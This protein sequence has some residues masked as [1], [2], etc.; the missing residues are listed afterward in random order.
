MFLLQLRSPPTFT[1]MQTMVL[2]CTV[3]IGLVSWVTP[4]MSLAITSGELT[5]DVTSEGDYS[6][7][8]S[9]LESVS[10]AALSVFVNG[11]EQTRANGGLKCGS[12]TQVNASDKY[13]A[14][15]GIQLECEAGVAPAAVPV[16][17]TWRAYPYPQGTPPSSTPSRLGK[18]AISL[19]LPLG[20]NGTQ[21]QTGPFVMQEAGPRQIAPFPAWTI[22][23][24]FATAALLCYGGDKSHLYSNGADQGG[25]LGKSVSGSCF[26]LGNGPGT[27]IWDA[28][29]ALGPTVKGGM[30]ALV[31][32]PASAFHLNYNTRFQP[33]A[34]PSSNDD[35]AVLYYNPARGDVTFCLSDNCKKTQVASGYTVLSPNEGHAAATCSAPACVLLCP[36]E[37]T[38]CCPA[39][40]ADYQRL[41]FSWSATN[42]DNWVTNTSGCPNPAYQ[43]CGN[44][45][46]AIYFKNASGRLSVTSFVN[47]NGTHHI[48]AATETSKQWALS[49]GYTAQGVLGYIDTPVAPP[50][51]T[52][53]APPAPFVWGFGVS[54]QVGTLP[55][56]F[57]QDTL[58]VH[59]NTGPTA[60]WDEW[61]ASIRK[62]WDTTKKADEDV[63]LTSL[64]IWTDNGAA[65]LGP[66]WR[67]MQ[68]NVVP[69]V[70][71][72]LGPNVTFNNWN[73]SMVS[74]EVLGRVAGG[75]RD[76]GVAPRATQL[77]CWWYPVTQPN[78]P[79]WCVSDW[80]LPE[81]FYPNGT[82]GVRSQMQVPL[83][84]YFP[85][86]CLL[87][88]WNAGGKYRWS[89]GTES[90]NFLVPTAVD[91]EIFWSDVFDY[92]AKLASVG[93]D[94]SD[95]W[96]G[97]WAPPMVKAGWKGTNLAAYETDF[98]HGLVFQTPEFRTVFGAGEMFLEGIHKACESHNMTAQI[99]AG[100]P[101][102][103]LEAL[104]MPTITNARAS[105]DYDWDGDPPANGGPRSN[106]GAHNWAAPDNGWVFWATR[107]APSKDN[108]WT[109]N[110]DLAPYGY[111][112][113]S[114]RNGMDAE[115]HAINAILTTGPVGIGDTCVGSTC[116][117][118]AS[119]V[120]RLARADGVLLRP[121]R[122]LAPVD[123][124]WAS[125]LKNAWMPNAIRQM[126]GLCTRAQ[127]HQGQNAS[128][129]S[130]LWQTHASVAIENNSTAP[131]LATSPTRKIVSHRAVDD[132]EQASVPNAQAANPMF[133]M[134][135]L[136]VSV[137]QP[138]EFTLELSDLYPVAPDMFSPTS[139]K[140]VFHRSATLE[141]GTTCASGT[142]AVSSGCISLSTHTS[143]TPPFNMEL[144]DLSTKS[145]A[146]SAG[147]EN[148]L[149]SV[150][151]WQ[152]WVADA[153]EDL[154]VLGDLSSYV[155]LSGYRFRLPSDADV[156]TG[157]TSM[158]VV[159]S[160]E[161][162]IDLTY[163]RKQQ[164][165][166]I[167]MVEHVTIGPSGRTIV[168]LH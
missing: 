6:L 107:I 113:D 162:T 160:P 115:L 39:S 153:S 95:V 76:T 26:N 150:G 129:G 25:L 54:G 67:P 68:P 155:S 66:A 165:K 47:T 41:Y 53:P 126:P 52:P 132:T 2:L 152:V 55:A 139:S 104:T 79:M 78:H 63:F 109:S 149:H 32:G 105:I 137:D 13:G 23:G 21:A 154:V 112:K 92:G 93:V 144:F 29:K 37:P 106:N 31:S 61:G 123:V 158:I 119:V 89:E 127:E 91:S 7:Q 49:H 156:A 18:I 14:F 19:E 44:D 122:P 24:A 131:E 88:I 110:P 48:A 83:M 51:P 133:L 143:G 33:N 130:R 81:K 40:G 84:L 147:A 50:P 60:A 146:C 142:D 90:S 45:D 117:M 75:V 4:A 82:G 111:R 168:S 1:C 27:L 100:N 101:P 11:A 9:D 58:V 116:F 17:F 74:T 36:G 124:M 114:G 163:L 138:S 28:A 140:V 72:K 96:P 161:E 64:T 98:Y 135:H 38:C 69:P 121:D 65:T 134:Q 125:L 157:I 151:L 80:V 85:A 3:V 166:W 136:V 148:C 99:C 118:N 5:L 86:P 145:S 34:N 35:K 159:G 8:V 102:S 108:F 70:Y 42:Q 15:V 87:N 43:N 71:T 103:F 167:V 164:E 73:W 57:V 59:A 62:R 56:G 10:G 12:A 94:D 128:C 141:G 30:H 16:V 20:A 22:E 120:K 97:V 77:D 46:G